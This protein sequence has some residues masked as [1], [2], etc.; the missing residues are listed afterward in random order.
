MSLNLC[1]KSVGDR[2]GVSWATVETV[3]A[4]SSRDQGEG[5]LVGGWVCNWTKLVVCTPSTPH[6]GVH[7]LWFSG[8]Q[9]AED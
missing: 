4:P 3:Q 9:V 2:V 1:H 6:C 5:E 7:T 8:L